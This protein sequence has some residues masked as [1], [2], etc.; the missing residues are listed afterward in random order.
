MR[1]NLK[2]WVSLYIAVVLA[3]AVVGAN[4]RFLGRNQQAMI[5]QKENL[6]V[7][8]T[9][10]RG[11]AEAIRGPKAIRAF[12]RARG[13]VP[14]SVIT[15]KRQITPSPAPIVTRGMSTGLVLRTEWRSLIR[16]V[17]P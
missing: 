14:S 17:T 8:L 11:R 12:A 2:A 5:D 1:V 10:L 9:E 7:E 3:L 6:R 16:G 4:N 15:E 13:M